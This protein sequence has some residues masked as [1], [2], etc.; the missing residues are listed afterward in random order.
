MSRLEKGAAAIDESRIKRLML[1]DADFSNYLN[2]RDDAE[3]TQ[4]KSPDLFIDDVLDYFATGGALKGDRC[5]FEKLDRV[6]RFG[7][8]QF[9]I[10]QGIN[11][12]GKSLV[13]GQI[14]QHFMIDHKVCIIS[15]EMTPVHLIARMV[16]QCFKEHMPAPEKIEAWCKKATGKLYIYDFQNAVTEDK[17]MSLIFYATE[18]LGIK[19]ILIDSL[20]KIQ[21]IDEDAYNKQK[22]FAAKLANVARHTGC[23][24]HLV[25]HSRKGASEDDPPNKMSVLGSSSIVNLCDNLFTVWRNKAK[26]NLDPALM[27]ED[28]RRDFDAQIIVQKNRHGD[29]EGIVGLYFDPVTQLYRE[30]L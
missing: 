11:G 5:G 15:P 21:D 9:S 16:K 20:M 4:L 24:I 8:G 12:H 3:H 7:E 29:W 25:A 27:T 1:E 10:W 28:E 6:F 2:E 22:L 14:F 26:Q 19:H 30:Q 18:K 23:H 17:L 13:L